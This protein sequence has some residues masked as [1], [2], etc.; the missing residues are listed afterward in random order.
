[1]NSG[2]DMKS[3]CSTFFT[4]LIAVTPTQQLTPQES[5]IVK[6]EYHLCSSRLLD[7]TA[8]DTNNVPTFRSLIPSHDCIIGLYELFYKIL[9]FPETFF[10]VQ[11]Q[12]VFS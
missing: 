6:F 10:S 2:N 4:V 1:M 12:S 8:G 3:T 5:F 11:F 9:L 7:N